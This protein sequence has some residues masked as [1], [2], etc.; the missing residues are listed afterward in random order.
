[1]KVDFYD[2]FS[3][4]TP[5][6]IS[7]EKSENYFTAAVRNRVH[8]KLSES[9]SA[10]LPKIRHKRNFGKI[11]LAAAAAAVILVSGTLAA[12]ALGI[13]D[14]EK[15]FRGIFT[16]G[17]EHLESNAAVPQN[18]VTTGDDRI[19]MRV[20]AI[21]GAESE[22]FGTIEIKRNDGGAFPENI[23]AVSIND[24][25]IDHTRRDDFSFRGYTSGPEVV[26]ETT[27]VYKF[28]I[29]HSSG[30]SIIGTEFYLNITDITD[31]ES[32][33]LPGEWSISFPLE[34]EYKDHIISVNESLELDGFSGTVTELKYAATALNITVK[35]E[36][37]ENPYVLVPVKIS[38]SD[39]TVLLLKMQNGQNWNEESNTLLLHYSLDDPI[40]IDRIE[41]IM[42]DDLVIP[43]K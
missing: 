34:Y 11:M 35:G 7:G 4:Y 13:I 5:D 1:M 14:I 31:T 17:F 29:Y 16:G 39:G 22:A 30:E 19:S 28:R 42:I 9:G 12:S 10:V 36:I 43:V 37:Y 15:I 20:L 21:G 40:D 8:E 24:N 32:V 33:I 23:S 41:S 38:F 18:V 6:E 3:L 27:A 25:I 26:D 2:L